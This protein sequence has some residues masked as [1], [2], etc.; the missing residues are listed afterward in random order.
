MKRIGAYR[1]SV[2]LASYQGNRRIGLSRI[3]RIEK[4][5]GAYGKIRGGYD[6]DQPAYSEQRGCGF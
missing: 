4:A 5:G 6:L 2:R 3:N 1:E